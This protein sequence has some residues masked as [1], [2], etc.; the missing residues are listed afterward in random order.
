[1]CELLLFLPLK[2]GELA[3]GPYSEQSSCVLAC[4]RSQKAAESDVI[5]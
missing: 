1:M 5:N 4:G 3:S 2:L